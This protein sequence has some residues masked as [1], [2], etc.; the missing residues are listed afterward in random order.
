[1][2][3]EKKAA[4]FKFDALATDEST[5]GTDMAQLSVF[6]ISIG[7]EYNIFEEIACLVSLKDT[8]KSMDLYEAVKIILT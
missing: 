1:M 6:I 2:N 7:N 8:S 5:D 3:L 4:H